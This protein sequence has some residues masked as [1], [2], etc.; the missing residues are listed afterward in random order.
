VAG[1]PDADNT[2]I[3]GDVG[4]SDAALGDVDMRR[5]LKWIGSVI[6]E[7]A[8]ANEA[9]V[10]SGSFVFPQRYMSVVAYNGGGSTIHATDSVFRFNIVPLYWQGQA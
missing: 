9:C 2:Q 10:A 8:A 5:N 7:N 6:S 1:A 4:T 3:D